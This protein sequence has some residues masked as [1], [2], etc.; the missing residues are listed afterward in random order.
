MYPNQTSLYIIATACDNNKECLMNEDEEDCK[1]SSFTTPILVSS[2]LGI[3]GIFVAMKISHVRESRSKKEERVEAEDEEGLYKDLIEKLKENPSD[4]DNNDG[5]N[6]YFLYI[7]STKETEWTREFF[8]EFYDLLATALNYQQA[9]LFCY[10]KRNL[11]Q[12]VTKAI[13]EHK[14]RGVIT[15]INTCLEKNLCSPSPLVSFNDTVT[16]TPRF[17]MFLSTVGALMGV[18]G[19]FT[20]IVKDLI[21]CIS[22][23]IVS[24]GFFAIRDFPTNFSTAVVLSWMGTIFVPILLSSVH[25]ALTDPFIV[26][27]S[28][29][30]RASRWGRVLAALGCLVLSPLNTVM[31]KTRLH[32][33]EEEAINAARILGDDTLDVYKECDEIEEK[34]LEY[35]HHEIGGHLSKIHLQLDPDGSFIF[36]PYSN[37]FFIF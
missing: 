12:T 36:S 26:F 22:L 18:I 21:L 29:R 6:R 11:H 1:N 28:A 20:D 23:L 35:L 17:R 3:L 37:V 33:K 13:V 31:L 25:L 9:E 32:L 8:I 7:L 24:G 14:F 15:K 30:L 5:L 34:L 4:K 10:M 2:L 16:A 19:H 27:N